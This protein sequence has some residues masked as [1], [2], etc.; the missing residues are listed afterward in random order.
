M[1]SGG[2]LDKIS[3]AL[4]GVWFAFWG[5]AFAFVIHIQ[6]RGQ[7]KRRNTGSAPTMYTSSFTFLR[8]TSRSHPRGS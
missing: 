6:T 3:F 7:V 2:G 8:L 1:V 5:E 4:G